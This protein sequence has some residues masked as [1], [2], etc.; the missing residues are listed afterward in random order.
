MLRPAPARPQTS[1]KQS[2]IRNAANNRFNP[3]TSECYPRIA[4]PKSVQ[5]NTTFSPFIT[6]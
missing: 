5:E 3:S 6:L 1:A 2:S 4:G